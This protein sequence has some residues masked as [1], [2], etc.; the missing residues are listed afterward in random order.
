MT[1]LPASEARAGFSEILNRV[2]FGGERIVLERHGRNVA[3]LV[4]MADFASLEQRPSKESKRRAPSPSVF[5]AIPE[6]PR[7]GPVLLAASDEGLWR[8]SFGRSR[9]SLEDRLHEELPEALPGDTPMLRRA[10]KELRE[11]LGG[12]RRRFDVR[13]DPAAYRTPFLRRVLLDATCAIPFGRVRT[14]GEI[15]EAVGSPAAARAVGGALAANPVPIVVPCHRV[16]AAGGRLGG[17]S[18]GREGTGLR[19]KKE[20]LALEGALPGAA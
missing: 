7:L 19:W 13:V 6:L 14:Y 18:G 12:G 11:Y 15:A 1:V 2:A 20:L 8:L 9:A 16:I 10:E 5:Y 4:P 3:A 17:Y